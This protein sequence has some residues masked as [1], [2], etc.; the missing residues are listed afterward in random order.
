MFDLLI[1]NGTVI[2]GRKTPRYSADIG[3]EGER[4]TAVGNL[5]EGTAAQVIDAAGKIVAPGFI[6]VHTHS[7]GWLLKEPHFLSKTKQGFTTEFLML[8][9]I[10]YAPVNEHTWREWLYYLRPLNGLQLH[11]YTGWR[12]IGD[13]MA[14]LDGRTAQHTAAFIPY[15][16]VRTLACGFGQRFPDDFQMY[17]IQRLIQQGMEEGALGLSTGLDYVDECFA[18]TDEL[19]TACRMMAAQGVY[20][21][22][23]RYALGTLAGVQEAVEIGKR[24]AVP[25][26]I[27][28]LK[29]TDPAEAEAI[30]TYIDTVAINEVDFS[31]DV[32]PYLPSST[33]LQYLLPHEV[34]LAGPIAALPKLT[35]P[36]LRARFNR[37]LEDTPL[38]E[39]T[40]AWIGS[41]GSSHYQGKTLAEYIAD[42]GTSPADALCDLLVEAGMAVLL[43]FHL[44]DD[45]LVMPFLAHNRYMMGSDGIYMP[46]GVIHP[47]QYGSAARLLGRY[48]REKRLFSLETAVY[49]LT[50]FP[51]SRFNLPQR[52]QIS[53]GYFADLVLFDE[54]T[55]A[56]K[57]TYDDPHQ[58]TIGVSDVVVNGRVILSNGRATPGVMPGRFLQSS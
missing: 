38:D 36:H 33:M 28:H 29:A 19:V 26:H 5:A 52:G 22:H 7:D 40:I 27:S 2:D 32:Y 17:E 20:V 46:G 31:F 55:I 49:K 15:A 4:I 39:V 9:G 21:T 53:E 35:D 14:L 57:A 58:L 51:A 12:S 41:K 10:S 30:L 37:A 16:N 42:M 43:V 3:I 50:G 48:V 56:D 8:D 45:D 6:D 44:G 11:E 24:A 1:R 25:V 34:W 54:Q 47:R 13:Y 18:T 23:V